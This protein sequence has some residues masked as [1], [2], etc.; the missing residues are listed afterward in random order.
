MKY[1]KCLS[2]EL[3]LELPEYV[4]IIWL[5]MDLFCELDDELQRRRFNRH[6]ASCTYIDF[7]II[8][9]WLVQ[10]LTGVITPDLK[11]H[12]INYRGITVTSTVYKPYCHNEWLTKWTE[13]NN[14]LSHFQNGFSKHRNT[15]A[16]INNWEPK[17]ATTEVDIRCLRRFQQSVIPDTK[18]SL[19]E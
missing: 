6:H 12:R 16:Y 10:Y 13:E 11:S 8:V 9:S 17:E 3:K 15:V 1:C 18:T 5:L 4:S 14:I 7:M 2:M 19:V